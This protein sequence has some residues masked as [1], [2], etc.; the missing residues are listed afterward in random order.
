MLGEIRRTDPDVL[1]LAEAFTRPPMMRA[2]AEVGF[3]QSYT[4]FTWRN[5]SGRSRSTCT[6]SPAKPPPHATP[7]FN[8]NTP[9][10]LH[11]SLQY[12]GPGCLRHPRHPGRHAVA[13]VRGVYSGFELYEHVALKRVGGVPRHREVLPPTARLRGSGGLLEVAWPLACVRP[14]DPAPAPGAAANCAI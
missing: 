3:H 1:F 14:R 7:T 10:I 6:T 2:L 4:Y 5:A 12:G 13:H 9:D 8:F 11:A